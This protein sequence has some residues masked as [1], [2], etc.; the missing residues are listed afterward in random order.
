[1]PP[2]F[3]EGFR[4]GLETLYRWRRDVRRFTADP[5]APELIARLVA[6][7]GL[8]PSV[9]DSRPWR[10]VRV[11]T[12]ARRA[13][14][15]EVF[16]RCNREALGG[17]A[18]DRARGYAS[19]KLAGLDAPVHLAVFHDDATERGHGLGSRTMPET[20]RY[21]TV[22]AIHSF[23][24]AARAEGLGVGWVSILDKDEV[25]ARLDVPASWTL[26]AYLCVGRPLEE[27]VDPEL[28]RVGWEQ[29]G[30]EALRLWER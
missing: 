20:L 21:S 22:I 27:H 7:A 1:M 28:E 6:L 4:D 26:I 23:W 11:D 5:V 25:S 14:I 9:G 24:L 13:A 16:E 15:R 29:P 17:Y 2:R 3:D 12:P 8:S 30:G 19:L 18:G 10:F